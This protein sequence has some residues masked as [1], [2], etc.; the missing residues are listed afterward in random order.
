MPYPPV[1]QFQTIERLAREV[2][3]TPVKEPER[4]LAAPAPRARAVPAWAVG[5]RASSCAPHSS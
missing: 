2:L 5:S 3:R 1:T 4:E